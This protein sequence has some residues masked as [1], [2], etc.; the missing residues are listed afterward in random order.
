VSHAS[1]DDLILHY[2]GEARPSADLESHLASCADCRARLEQLRADLALVADDD[3]PERDE[4][5][6]AEVWRRVGG[7]LAAPPRPAPVVAKRAPRRFVLPLAMAAS[8]LLAFLV[9][10]RFPSPEHVATPPI[11]QVRER[12]LLVAVGTHLERSQMVLVELANA[13]PSRP[14]D[15][16]AERRS[17]D[18]LVAESRLYRQ[19]AVRAGEPGVA[20]VL[21]EL[22]RVLIEVAH[23]PSPLP[24][25]E[26]A[27]IQR[28]I[29]ARGV[30]F[31]IRVLGTQ[32]RE[33][34]REAVGLPAGSVS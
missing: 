34:Q 22:E 3:V 9:G 18:E 2:Y 24:A 25:A 13:D 27:E 32:V 30:L 28:R 4:R 7:R 8:L 20:S 31:K 11:E 1:E 6:G 12:I 29:E 23:S 5:Y 33:R 21:D 14:A 16:E 26:L 10:R 15:I 17:A 19:A